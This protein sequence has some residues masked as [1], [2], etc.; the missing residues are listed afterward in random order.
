MLAPG[1]C[2]WT[3]FWSE[4]GS[5]SYHLPEEQVQAHENKPGPGLAGPETT[6]F[7]V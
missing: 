5:R 6:L 3:P 2:G 7:L 1:S 4:S